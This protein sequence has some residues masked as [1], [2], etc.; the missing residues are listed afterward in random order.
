MQQYFWGSGIGTCACLPHQQLLSGVCMCRSRV[1][2]LLVPEGY[3][4]QILYGDNVSCFLC[5]WVCS[6]LPG[7]EARLC[8]AAGAGGRCP[9][10][11]GG[12]G[13]TSI[14][15]CLGWMAVR[16]QIKGKVD[17][18]RHLMTL[19]ALQEHIGAARPL[20]WW[21]KRAKYHCYP[22]SLC[23][24]AAFTMSRHCC[25]LQTVFIRMCQVSSLSGPKVTSSL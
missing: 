1:W 14:I 24:P 13:G 9:W 23:S 21:R 15:L 18:W 17:S 2:T 16:T 20:F 3:Q 8:S 5:V 10:G 6:Q 19:E 7:V 22:T 25:S 12:G 4:Q 11:R